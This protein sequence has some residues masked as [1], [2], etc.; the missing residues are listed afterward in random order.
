EH[1][2]ARLEKEA[3]AKPSAQIERLFQLALCRSPR[4]AETGDALEFL[5][6][7]AEEKTMRPLA[8]LC[9]VL[10][11]TNEFVYQN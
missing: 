6:G 1:L 10:L 8:A 11:N 4:A 2:A 7:A 3:G 5:E 9:L